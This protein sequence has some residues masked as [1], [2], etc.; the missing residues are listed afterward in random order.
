VAAQEKKETISES[1]NLLRVPLDIIPREELE[2]QISKLLYWPKKNADSSQE[3]GKNLVLLSLWDLLRARRRNEYRNYVLKSP[4]VI[5][6]SKS[7]VGGARFLR[8]KTPIRYMPFHFIVDLLSI[9]ETR[10]CTVYL[11]GST[12]RTL[13]KVE[14]NIRQTFPGLRIVGRCDSSFRRQNEGAIV[15]AIRKTSPQLLLVGKGVRGEELW[16]A[17]HHKNLN[18]GLRLWCSDIFDVFAEKK[19]RPPEWVFNA[20][21]ESFIYGIKK[22]YRIF[23]LIPYFRYKLLLLFYKILKKS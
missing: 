11:L 10:E 12:E 13:R 18:K 16:I 6:I 19:S 15:E 3:E 1:L 4:M 17:R 7:L 5:P 9:L 22:P 23:R 20:G 21:L 8:G 14:N 2:A